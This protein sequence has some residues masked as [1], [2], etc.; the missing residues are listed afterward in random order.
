MLTQWVICGDRWVICSMLHYTSLYSLYIKQLQSIVC[1]VTYYRAICA[2]L[3]FSVA[4]VI[5]LE[6]T[7]NFS[8]PPN[9]GFTQSGEKPRGNGEKN[10][11]KMRSYQEKS[12]PLQQ[13]S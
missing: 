2:G 5:N 4:K 10:G 7:C 6:A 9:Q 13:S 1:N 8:L 11:E 3:N 12:V